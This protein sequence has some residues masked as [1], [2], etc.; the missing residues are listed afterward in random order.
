MQI[1]GLKPRRLM[2]NEKTEPATQKYQGGHQSLL[3]LYFFLI[4]LLCILF[5]NQ[6]TRVTA[7]IVLLRIKHTLLPQEIR[8]VVI[9]DQKIK[10]VIITEVSK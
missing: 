1:Q 10:M 7:G 4:F 5:K 6:V 9:E 3:I 8:R 2:G